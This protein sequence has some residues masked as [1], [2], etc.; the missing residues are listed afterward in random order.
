MKRNKS[1]F[2][3]IQCEGAVVIQIGDKTERVHA[4]DFTPSDYSCR[5]G[6]HKKEIE[7]LKKI[8]IESDHEIQQILGKVLG[9]PWYKDDQKNFPGATEKDGVCTGEHVA[10]TLAMEAADR[11]KH[12]EYIV[13]PI[14]GSIDRSI[15]AGRKVDEWVAYAKEL[16]ASLGTAVAKEN[17]RLRARVLEVAEEC[18]SIEQEY[19][20]TGDRMLEIDE[21]CIRLKGVIGRGANVLT[22]L[23]LYMKQEGVSVPQDLIEIARASE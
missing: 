6:A 23:L 13:E 1:K 8:G 10:A 17:V 19:N 18:N 14:Q 9:Y 3:C 5:R 11:I 20:E 12:L 15:A 7:R 2:P 4:D 22:K 21:E 16:E